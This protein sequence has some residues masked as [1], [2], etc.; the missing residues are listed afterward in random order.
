MSAQRAMRELREAKATFIDGEQSH[1]DYILFGA[2]AILIVTF[3]A[4]EYVITAGLVILLGYGIVT[5]PDQ[6]AAVVADVSLFIVAAV[7]AVFGLIGVFSIV[8]HLVARLVGDGGA[9][10]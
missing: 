8:G 9:S 6:T 7:S 3:E 4:T 5:R 10:E 2:V 1:L